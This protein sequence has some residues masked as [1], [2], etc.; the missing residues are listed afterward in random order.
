MG[1]TIQVTKTKEDFG[2]SEG[3]EKM[4]LRYNPHIPKGKFVVR[5]RRNT[6]YWYYQLSEKR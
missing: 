1:E 4:M 6:F 3:E 2:W 5:K